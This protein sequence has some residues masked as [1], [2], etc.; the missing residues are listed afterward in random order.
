MSGVNKFMERSFTEK[1]IDWKKNKSELPLM[2][3]GARQTGKT[4]VIKKFCEDHFESYLYIN[5]EERPEYLS[6]FEENLNPEEIIKKIEAF[7]GEKINVEKTAIFIDEIQLSE[8]AV[9]SLKYFSESDKNYKVL[10]AGS[11]LGVA[12]NRFSS[13]FPVGKVYI[14]RLYPMDFEE[15]L[16]ATGE[17]LLNDAVT[18]SYKTLKPLSEPLHK[19][20]VSLYRSYLC[21]GGMPAAVKEFIKKEKDLMLF[22]RNV[23]SNIIFSYL[24]DMSKYT[25]SAQAVKTNKVYN[26]MPSQLAKTN[27]KFKYSLVDKS[28]KKETY[29]SAIDWLL[30]A[31]LLLKSVKTDLPQTPL[32]AYIKDGH[33]KLFLSDVGLLVTL[34]KLNFGDIILGT[35][36]IYKGILTE[37][38]VAQS[39]F[40]KGVDLY[41]WESGSN[42]E[43]DFILEIDGKIIPVEVKSSENTRSKSLQSYVKKYD[44]PYAIRISLKNFGY[45]NKIRSIPL[46]AVH[47]I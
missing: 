22:D 10:C 43:V 1:L 6:F 8:K 39:F 24:A 11:L 26:S 27:K 37:N 25:T 14:E 15:F 44:P 42:A 2:V 17:S 33:F 3:I 19:K 23:H 45:V 4:S 29:E 7:R 13:S 32:S 35:S 34:S 20:A 18:K 9:T 40:S 38:Y 31:G 21:V 16:L 36:M 41:Y 12:L 47:L 28:A 30:D 5:F 46:Y